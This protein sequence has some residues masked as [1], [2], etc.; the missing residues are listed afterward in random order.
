MDPG[1]IGAQPDIVAG[2]DRRRARHAP[3]QLLAG[4]AEQHIGFSAQM[5]DLT[6]YLGRKPGQLS[7]GQRQRVAIGRCLFLP[8]FDPVC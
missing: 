4:L 2:R 1:R 5:L 8:E 3:A 7:G 6:A